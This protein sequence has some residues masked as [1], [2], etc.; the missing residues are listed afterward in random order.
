MKLEAGISLGWRCET[1]DIAVQ[2]G[3]RLRRK[4]G[5]KTCPFDIMVSNYEGI[6]KCI[7][8]DFKYF[9]DPNYLELRLAPP[10]KKHLGENQ[11]DGEYFIYN[12]YYNFAFNHESPGHG[13][14]YI[15]E[16]WPSGINHYVNNNYEN[17][18]IKYTAR[19]NNFRYYLNNCTKIYFIISRYNALPHKLV[20]IIST[21]YPNLDFEMLTYINMS[22]RTMN[23]TLSKNLNGCIEFET[24]YLRYMLVTDPT[25]YERFYN[26]IIDV[27]PD[28]C[29]KRIKIKY[30]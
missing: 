21:K 13:D 3:Y 2:T 18:I 19:I 9:C 15:T 7:D 29:D 26:E 1:A 12:T 6:C 17:F 22:T 24:E 5:Y 28:N 25:E 14:L 11:K 27:L 16:N 23:N 20:N 30:F 10:M 4:D 8:D